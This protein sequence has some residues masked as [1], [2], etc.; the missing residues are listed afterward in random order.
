MK[1]STNMNYIA[2]NWAEMGGK[3]I[4]KNKLVIVSSVPATTLLLLHYHFKHDLNSPLRW[5]K[6]C[7]KLQSLLLVCLLYFY[8]FWYKLCNFSFYL[9]THKINIPADRLSVYSPY[10]LVP[11]L[12]KPPLCC[13]W[14][15]Q[16]RNP[17]RRHCRN[18]T[19]PRT[20]SPS[21][22]QPPS[23]SSL[24][25]YQESHPFPTRRQEHVLKTL[26]IIRVFIIQLFMSDFLIEKDS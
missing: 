3:K 9:S 8:C 20:T 18:C 1:Q 5:Y 16:G 21:G 13:R 6:Y 22:W 24:V 23:Q 10:V 25:S 19:W 4:N 14:P 15:A 26:W 2:F 12:W 11:L 7:T 17:R